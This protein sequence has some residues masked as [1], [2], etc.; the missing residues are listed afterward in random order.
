MSLSGKH[1]TN[2]GVL[3]DGGAAHW[4]LR[5]CRRIGATIGGGTLGVVL[6]IFFWYYRDT[7]T[8]T[9]PRHRGTPDAFWILY[10]RFLLSAGSWSDSYPAAAG[11]VGGDSCSWAFSLDGAARDGSRRRVR[12]TTAMRSP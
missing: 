8:G 10:W 5:P 4:L 9:A 3:R 11:S 2:R 6:A 7:A 1:V 12:S